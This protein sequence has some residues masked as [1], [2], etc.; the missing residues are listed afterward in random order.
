M[1][2]DSK[3]STL[4]ERR[5]HDSPAEKAENASTDDN[6]KS[7]DSESTPPKAGNVDKDLKKPIM[8]KFAK[9]AVPLFCVCYGLYFIS[10]GVK[11]LFG[12]E[13]LPVVR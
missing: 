10:R 13:L 5:R 7:A 8:S 9:M 12:V 3:A 1:A 2:K 4:R 11:H 6:A